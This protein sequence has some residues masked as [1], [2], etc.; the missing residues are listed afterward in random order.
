MLKGPAAYWLSNSFLPDTFNLSNTY[1]YCLPSDLSFHCIVHCCL[2]CGTPYSTRRPNNTGHCGHQSMEPNVLSMPPLKLDLNDADSLAAWQMLQPPEIPNCLQLS[3]SALANPHTTIS[4]A[5]SLPD[6]ETQEPTRKQICKT[7][8]TSLPLGKH[9]QSR[10]PAAISRQFEDHASVLGHVLGSLNL[11]NLGPWLPPALSALAAVNITHSKTVSGSPRCSISSPSTDTMYCTS[12]HSLP[13]NEQVSTNSIRH[14]VLQ[15]NGFQQVSMLKLQEMLCTVHPNFHLIFPCMSV[16]L[17]YNIRTHSAT[18][19]DGKQQ[20]EA[21]SSSSW[22]DAHGF[23]SSS[24]PCSKKG[25]FVLEEGALAGLLVSVRGQARLPNFDAHASESLKLEHTKKL[26]SGTTSGTTIHSHVKKCHTTDGGVTVCNDRL[27]VPHEDMEGWRATGCPPAVRASGSSSSSLNEELMLLLDLYQKLAPTSG[28]IHAETE[29]TVQGMYHG[30]GLHTNSKKTTNMPLTCRPQLP[31]HNRTFR[32][33]Q[34]SDSGQACDDVRILSTV[35]STSDLSET[36]LYRETSCRTAS[37]HFQPVAIINQAFGCEEADKKCV[38]RQ[39]LLLSD[40]DDTQKSQMLDKKVPECLFRPC[41]DDEWNVGNSSVVESGQCSTAALHQDVSSPEADVSAQVL[42]VDCA[43]VDCGSA[44]V[45]GVDC[46]DV[47]CGSAQVLGVDCADVDCGSALFESEDQLPGDDDIGSLLSTSLSSSLHSDMMLHFSHSS[48]PEGDGVGT[49]DYHDQDTQSINEN[50]KTHTQHIISD[51]D[52]ISGGLVTDEHPHL[53]IHRRVMNTALI[54]SDDMIMGHLH[55]SSAR[56]ELSKALSVSQRSDARS[57]CRTILWGEDAAAPQLSACKAG[58][59]ETLANFAEDEDLTFK[60]ES[61][62]EWLSGVNQDFHQ[63]RFQ[64]TSDGWL[65]QALE[66][67]YLP[68]SGEALPQLIE[69]Q[70][71]GQGYHAAGY[72]DQQDLSSWGCTSAEEMRLQQQLM[73]SYQAARQVESV[74]NA[75]EVGSTT[76][77]LTQGDVLNRAGSSRECPVGRTYFYSCESDACSS[78]LAQHDILVQCSL[79]VSENASRSPKRAQKCAASR[80]SEGDVYIKPDLKESTMYDITPRSRIQHHNAPGFITHHSDTSGLIPAWQQ[81]PNLPN[82]VRLNSLSHSGTGPLSAQQTLLATDSELSPSFISS[83][84]AYCSQEPAKGDVSSAAHQDI[85]LKSGL[86][87]IVH[88]DS[89]C[90][91]IVHD[92]SPCGHIVHGDSPCGH[93]VHG[94][95]PCGHIVHDD[96]PCGHIVHGDS[97]CG[98]IVHGDSPCGQHGTEENAHDRRDAVHHTPAEC[99]IHTMPLRSIALPEV[100]PKPMMSTSAKHLSNPELSPDS[101]L[102]LNPQSKVEFSCEAGLLVNPPEVGLTEALKDRVAVM[103]EARGLHHE[104]D[105]DVL[106]LLRFEHHVHGLD[107]FEKVSRGSNEGLKEEETSMEPTES[108]ILDLLLSERRK[109]GHEGV[110]NNTRMCGL[111]ADDVADDVGAA[112]YMQRLP[113]SCLFAPQL[114]G[115]STAIPLMATEGLRNLLDSSGSSSMGD[116]YHVTDSGKCGGLSSFTLASSDGSLVTA[117]SL[118]ALVHMTDERE[119]ALLLDVPSGAAIEQ[120]PNPTLQILVSAYTPETNYCAAASERLPRSGVLMQ[121]DDDDDDNLPGAPGHKVHNAASKVCP[122]RYP[123]GSLVSS[124]DDVDEC[125]VTTSTTTVTHQRTQLQAAPAFTEGCM[126]P[127]TFGENE[128]ALGVQNKNAKL[129]GGLIMKE[130]PSAS[131][132]FTPQADV[133]P[134]VHTSSMLVTPAEADVSPSVHTSNMLV[135]PAEADVSPSVHTSNMLVTPA[136]ADVS[137]SVHTSSIQARANQN[138]ER[139]PSAIRRSCRQYQSIPTSTMLPSTVVPTSQGTLSMLPSTVVPTSQGTLSMLPSTVVPTSQGTLSMLPSTVVPTSQGTL[140]MLPS[141]VVPTSQGTL[142]THHPLIGTPPLPYSR[143][144]ELTLGMDSPLEI[145][146]CLCY[147]DHARFPVLQR[148]RLLGPEGL[149]MTVCLPLLDSGEAIR[150]EVEG[151]LVRPSDQ[152][153]IPHSVPPQQQLL[154]LDLPSLHL[155]VIS[156]LDL[157]LRDNGSSTEILSNL[158]QLRHLSYRLV[159]AA[160]GEDEEPDYCSSTLSTAPAVHIGLPRLASSLPCL[161]VLELTPVDCTDVS[162]VRALGTAL[163]GLTSLALG[164]QLNG[165]RSHQ[166]EQLPPGLGIKTPSFSLCSL[167]PVSLLEGCFTRLVRLSLTSPFLDI[168]TYQ[169]CSVSNSQLNVP[170]DEMMASEDGQQSSVEWRARRRCGYYDETE[171]RCIRSSS[172]TSTL[173]TEIRGPALPSMPLLEDLIFEHCELLLPSLFQYQEE[174]HELQPLSR[175][176][177]QQVVTGEQQVLLI[178]PTEERLVLDTTDDERLKQ[179]HHPYRLQQQHHPYRLQQQHHPYRLQQQH[180]PCRCIATEATS[181]DPLSTRSNNIAAASLTMHDSRSSNNRMSGLWSRDMDLKEALRLVCLQQYGTAALPGNKPRVGDILHVT[182]KDEPVLTQASCSSTTVQ[183]V[184]ESEDS[185]TASWI[186]G[187]DDGM[188][189]AGSLPPTLPLQLMPRLRRVVFRELAAEAGCIP[190][191]IGSISL[192]WPLIEQDPAC[193]LSTSLLQ[194]D[195]EYD[196]DLM[197]AASRISPATAAAAAAATSAPAGE[198]SRYGW[199]LCVVHRRT[200][201]DSVDRLDVEARLGW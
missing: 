144:L 174:N 178:G 153:V 113:K 104:D 100:D 127:E 137:P 136:E 132:M 133:P 95:S 98:H 75:L 114:S 83:L 176:A 13:F 91:H 92:D 12:M 172:S 186:S 156:N 97:P 66:P 121:S 47:D 28:P 15:L 122:A 63:T 84:K 45:L 116:N 177:T 101:H 87:H 30:R 77:D 46:A 139:P 36:H 181:A 44:Q 141:T 128:G 70:Q 96:S 184:Q 183:A 39:Q 161:E 120:L 170:A 82:I 94:D 34:V 185:S 16:Q 35:V 6:G 106:C 148:L 117:T 168:D 42:G 152:G 65:Q 118:Q 89:P 50:N 37:D 33:V 175:Q 125:C 5:A 62:V 10:K 138:Q 187:C 25:V 154:L 198:G 192:R 182:P 99:G 43:D 90:G 56:S 160:G 26:T 55:G 190:K 146:R 103:N 131:L 57:C 79:Q 155:L 147:L 7:I 76:Q 195:D 102:S 163:S 129:D 142:S 145:L 53:Y 189:P 167:D 162:G 48:T 88:G 157:R 20:T 58:S 119:K 40:S 140:S 52:R 191:H 123:K 59:A 22:E 81:T 80:A 164:F 165:G 9:S 27:D 78:A 105:D 72:E 150:R 85:I 93:I 73:E 111:V 38:I 151:P 41:C 126:A 1:P 18:D 107:L 199:D 3:Y 197:F 169:R 188:L 29:L 130:Q 124:H 200:F 135:T 32:A 61:D 54:N 2:S 64:T 71:T 112:D 68:E 31:K 171:S 67:V 11:H 134:S 21:E 173:S 19:V 108:P 23:H 115:G 60:F 86:V 194:G 110:E 74:S 179:Q 143:L 17:S 180:H 14:L 109:L 69:G 159:A 149:P 196:G 49:P 166:L 8:Q 24:P 193:S 158:T 201:C 51:T 4:A